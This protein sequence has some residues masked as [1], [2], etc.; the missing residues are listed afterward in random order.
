MLNRITQN[1]IDG[2]KNLNNPEYENLKSF[3]F[4]K[5]HIIGTFTQPNAQPMFYG[6]SMLS[7]SGIQITK[8]YMKSVLIIM[9]LGPCRK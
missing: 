5:Y 1:I 8:Y 7:G 4:L 2:D 6:N 3:Q 9:E